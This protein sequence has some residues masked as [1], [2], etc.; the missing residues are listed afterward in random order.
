MKTFTFLVIVLSAALCQAQIMPSMV[1][2]SMKVLPNKE[3]DIR[4]TYKM[5]PGP[6][7]ALAGGPFS[8]RKIFQQD[9]ELSNGTKISRQTPTVMTYKNSAGSMRVEWPFRKPNNCPPEW[10]LPLQVEFIDAVAGYHYV[11]DTVHHV[12]HRGPIEITRGKPAPTTPR[13]AAQAPP[14]PSPDSNRPRS[15]TEPLGNTVIDGVAVEGSRTTTVYPAGSRM[16]N[17]RPVTTTS[18]VWGS[19]ELGAPLFRKSNDPRSGDEKSAYFDIDRNEP[20]PALFQVPA[21]YQIVDES[22]PFAITFRFRLNESGKLEPI[23]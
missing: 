4:A 2:S 10:E 16:G 14:I 5:E 21:D 13:A 12:A 8:G 18:E 19:P 23:N 17:D 20:N 1:T 22:G 9:Q 11:L 3:F 6:I 7:P 15:S